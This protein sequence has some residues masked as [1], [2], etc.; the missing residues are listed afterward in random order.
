MVDSPK[1]EAEW[2]LEPFRRPEGVNSDLISDSTST[3]YCPL[4]KRTVRWEARATFN[5]AAA[6][7]GDTVHVLYRAEDKTGR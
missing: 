3:F 2:M 4:R 7:Q 5:S 1:T 6:V